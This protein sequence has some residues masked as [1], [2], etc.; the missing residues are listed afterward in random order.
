MD[1]WDGPS[2]AAEICDLGGDGPPLDFGTEVGSWKPILKKV[3][4]SKPIL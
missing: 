3:R 4:S 2:R 1:G